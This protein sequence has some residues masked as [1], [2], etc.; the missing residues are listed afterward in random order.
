[1]NPMIVHS[2]STSTADAMIRAL[3]ATKIMI[4]MVAGRM[5]GASASISVSRQHRLLRAP[6][7]GQRAAAPFHRPPGP[8]AEQIQRGQHRRRR[9]VAERAQRLADDVARDAVQQ[10]D[11]F[12]ATLAALD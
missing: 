5:Y 6:G 7:C 4:P 11:V 10:I 2:A 8:V 12:R 1:M 3:N 9:G